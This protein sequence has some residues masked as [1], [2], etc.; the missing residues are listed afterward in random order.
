MEQQQREIVRKAGVSREDSNP[1][2]HMMR[3]TRIFAQQYVFEESSRSPFSS[4]IDVMRG[5]PLLETINLTVRYTDN[6]FWENGKSIPHSGN[7]SWVEFINMPDQLDSFTVEWET[8]LT[9]KAALDALMRTLAK[10]WVF[11]KADGTL[12]HCDGN[13]KSYTWT[14]T[15]KFVGRSF[16][17]HGDGPTMEYYVV[18]ATWRPDREQAESEESPLS[19]Q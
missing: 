10:R 7:D 12:M 9:R 11:H 2:F 14:G 8:I 1:K 4:V 17:H 6:W 16:A 3:H 18:K 19:Q 13:F 5:A 15:S